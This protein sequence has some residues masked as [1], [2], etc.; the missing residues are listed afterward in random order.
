MRT[1]PPPTPA[2]G[3]DHP[4]RITRTLAVDAP[5]S[6]VRAYLADFS[7][8]EA[9]DPG[10][11]RCARRG[12]GGEP[13]VGSQWDN[14]SRLFGITTELVYELVRLDDDH[15]VLRGEN[16]RSVAE[17]DLRLVDLG[18]ERTEIT[19]QATITFKGVGKVV[20]PLARLL[21]T[22]VARDVVENLRR[23]CAT[24]G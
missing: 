21:F 20:D 23:E 3:A 9:W 12:D 18:D 15:V 10:T 8:A 4:V 14:T 22:K 16:E 13:R 11:I 2:S 7:N 6:A 17:D 1:R 5:L 24:L 19:Y